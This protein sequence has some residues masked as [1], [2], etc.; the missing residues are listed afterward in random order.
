VSYASGV[1][2][3][4]F[5]NLIRNHKTFL[6]VGHDEYWSGAQRANVEAA[7]NA[8]VNLAFFS[9]NDIFW[10]TRYE[11]SIDGSNTS[12]RTLVSYKETHANAVIDPQDPPTW[13]GTWRDPRFSPPADG[14]RPE[15]ALSGTIFVVN[16]PRNDTITV[17][18]TDGKMRFWRNTSIAT[19]AAG[20]TANLPAGTLGAEWDQDADNGFRPPGLIR[21]SSTTLTL[22]GSW[23]L[24]DFGSTYGSGTATHHLTLYRHSSGAL[25]F[26]AGTYQWPWGL[27]SNHDRGSGA[28]D[29]RMQ[30]ATVNLLADM[31]V[32]PP[33]LQPGLIAASASTDTTAPVSAITLPAGG[34]SLTSGVPITV[35]GTAS[36]TGGGVVGGVEVSVDGGTTWHPATS[37]RASWTY[38]WTPQGNFSTTI[39][40]RA[41]DD[42]GNIEAPGAGVSV[43]VGAGSGGGGC[44]CSVWSASTVPGNPNESDTQSVNLG[45]KFTADTNGSITAIRFYKG[46]G[47]TGTH[48]GSLWTSTGQLLASATFTGETA[49]GWQQVN[50]SSPV[51]IT[52]GAVYVASYLAPAG[53]YAADVNFFA[54]AGV[55]APP[56]HL[57][58]NGASGGNGVYAYSSINT[59][60]SSTF[61]STNYWVDVV[62][63][64]TGTDSTPPMVTT[65]SPA[66]GAT[67][68]AVGTAVTATFSE[69]IDPTTVSGSTFFLRDASQQ[70]LPATVTYDGTTRT[71]R[72]QPNAALTT[73]ATYTATVVGGTTDPRVKD[74]AGNAL[75]ASVT[76]S[77][78]TS[79]STDTTPPTVTTTSPANGATGVSGT[80]T[81]SATFSE[82]MD[83]STIT[84]STFMLTPSGGSPVA[85]NVTYNTANF[86]AT[87]TPASALAGNTTYTATVVG[88]AIDPRAKDV[89][90]NA[91]A[92][93]ASWSFT[94]GDTTPPTITVTSPVAGA[95][96]VSGTA[97]VSATFS[98]AMNSATINTTTF[99]LRDAG[100]NVVSATVSYNATSHVATLNPTP[101]LTAGATYTATIIGG[102][103]GVTDAAGNSLV[104]NKVWS[105]TIL[106]DTTGPTVTKT[107]PVAGATG[108]SRSTNV[109]ATFSE[110]M[111]ATTITTGTFVLRDPGGSL[112][113]A[114]VS[115]NA[116]SHVATLNPAAS[117][118]YGTNYSAT[119]SSGSGGVKDTSGNPMSADVTWTFQTVFDTTPPTVTSTSPKNG[120]TGVSRT[121]S[122]SAT[123]SEA[124][125][126][127]TV[128]GS[129]VTLVNTVTGAPIA[130]TVSLSTNQRTAT[131]KSSTSLAAGTQFTARIVGGANGVTDLSGNPLASDFVW[132]FTT[133]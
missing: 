66:S 49:S 111:D 108:I 122:V 64:S 40:S 31:H 90:G 131:F 25:V 16:G 62:F 45:V 23:L 127:A 43:T 133:R 116:T 75:T 73:S 107:S 55:D 7:R 70:T 58:K 118:A 79:A 57:L 93:N 22:S 117:L 98:E 104:A 20:Q 5:G 115:Y 30:Q 1:D 91:L 17:P 21:L 99:V 44:P 69:A 11:A 74:L 114:T 19:L 46:S 26:G 65:M 56:L 103:S 109:T 101:T 29:A 102:P 41:V 123:F 33:N 24:Q 51:S 110:A 48:I 112:V 61:N 84:A 78:T 77:F 60:P 86:T 105:F 18:D 42:S 87:L 95:V 27:D 15:N 54:T 80:A 100:N 96:G 14:G 6:S 119:V 68:I 4:R 125:D 130:G 113:S 37:G 128:N 94:T 3:D 13:T 12:Y 28:P 8:G 59:F 129:T 92:A 39:K 85:A 63:T 88:G 9:G 47:N 72:L 121:A 71:A 82:A 52:A 89:A 76:W 2:G 83:P 10:K 81:V 124:V 36:D 120:T 38:S 126:P 67:G 106:A 34:A 53:H 97:N 132:S 35:T 32:Q 50:F